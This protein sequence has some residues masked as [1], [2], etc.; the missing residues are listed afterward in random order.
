MNY[1]NSWTEDRPGQPIQS[2]A[3]LKSVEIT[4]SGN[5]FLFEY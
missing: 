5:F 1:R 4:T 3:F 2:N